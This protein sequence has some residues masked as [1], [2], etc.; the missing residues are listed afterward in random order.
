MRTA[1]CISTAA[2]PGWYRGRA[3]HVHV[4]VLTTAYN[5]AD[6]APAAAVTQLLWADDFVDSIFTNVPIYA[7]LGQPDTH[8]RDDNVVGNV[9]DQAPFLFETEQMSDGAML[10]SK[11]IVVET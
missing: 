10:C 1:S 6:N 9:G 3:V 2:S 11:T 7:E 4:R 8:L 5:G